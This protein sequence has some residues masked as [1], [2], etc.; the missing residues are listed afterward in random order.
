MKLSKNR[1]CISKKK[2]QTLRQDEVEKLVK[3]KRITRKQAIRKILLI[4]PFVWI[5]FLL[6]A[7]SIDHYHYEC[8]DGG[9]QI[10]RYAHFRKI[11]TY[12]CPRESLSTLQMERVSGYKYVDTHVHYTANNQIMTLFEV[13]GS[14]RA[15][16][17]QITRY[18]NKIKNLTQPGQTLWLFPQ[19]IKCCC[20]IPFLLLFTLGIGFFYIQFNVEDAK[21]GNPFKQIHSNSK[22]GPY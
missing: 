12:F 5:F 20:F 16:Q 15:A 7:V 4:A 3:T 18:V 1:I 11:E 8:I 13:P 14:P 9:I 21:T 6:F 2:L 22:K 17:E 19:V 10:A